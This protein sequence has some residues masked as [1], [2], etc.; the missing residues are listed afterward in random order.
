MQ[1]ILNNGASHLEQR[2]KINANTAEL[3][4]GMAASDAHAA[5]VGNPHA[6]TATQVGL[7]SVE[8]KSFAVGVADATHNA[9]TKA[10]PVDAD[11]FPVSDSGNSYT[12]R[13]VSWGSTKISLRS[14]FDLIYQPALIS[15]TNIKTVN[16]SSLL[17]SGDLTIAGVGG[18]SIS[19]QD[20]GAALTTAATSLNFIGGG[21]TAT[22]I[23]GAVTVSVPTAPV[24]A[25]AGR[26]GAVTLG[27][28]DV[29]GAQPS[30]VS[31]FNIK[32]VNGVSLLGSGDMTIAGGGGITTLAAAS[33]F[34]TAALATGNASIF[35]ALS[36]KQA[37][38][39][40]GVNIKTIN[41]APV[42]GGGDLVVGGATNLT[43]AAGPAS[44][45]VVSD[46]GSDATIPA[47]DGTNSGLMLPAQFTKLAGIVDPALALSA[48]TYDGS[49]RV[50]GFTRGSTVFIV[51]YPS[52]T[53]ITITGGGRVVTITLDGSG[54]IIGKTVA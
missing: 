18:G 10:T 24:T 36:G 19:V 26:T 28:A 43:Y 31:G 22:S 9:A 14:Y 8:N 16:G 53:S 4:A 33:D 46:T 25:V 21:V 37:S 54:R 13:K 51:A 44:G 11:E 17:G 5:S 23:G 30:L 27:V 2:T 50:T 45:L 52:G 20:E 38:L 47:A 39:V 15:G 3:Y 7:G 6:V 41:G 42:L 48:V 1:Q 35:S 34:A 49:N 12:I 40:S 32:T 29:T